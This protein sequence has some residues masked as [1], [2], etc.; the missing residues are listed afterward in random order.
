MMARRT[1]TP[2]AFAHVGR[3]VDYET[4]FCCSVYPA[5]R[6]A[7]GWI[8]GGGFGVMTAPVGRVRF[9]LST[10]ITRLSGNSEQGEND[11]WMGAG[12]M[13]GI[14]LGAAIPVGATP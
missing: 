11:S 5:S 10:S 2:Y 12:P 8:V 13:V 9:E 6:D 14:R 4:S 7:S 1:L 3:V